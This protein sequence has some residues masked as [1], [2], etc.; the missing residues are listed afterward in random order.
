MTRI[1]FR[2]GSALYQRNSKLGPPVIPPRQLHEI[3]AM[4]A[5]VVRD[6]TGRR[7]RLAGARAAG[8]TGTSQDSRDA[9]FVGYADGIV[10]GVWLGADDNAP[11]QGVVGGGAPASI[12]REVMETAVASPLAVRSR[13][14]ASI[15]AP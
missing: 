11:M 13:D 9:W 14:L 12:W 15:G 4:L 2:G 6:G 8:K 10:S 5:G 3:D 1:A 7:A